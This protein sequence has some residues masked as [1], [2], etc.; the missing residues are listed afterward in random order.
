MKKEETIKVP[1]DVASAAELG[2]I[3]LHRGFKG[4][5]PTGWNRAK[6]LAVDKQ[7][8]VST[9]RVMRA[10]FARHGPDARTG[11]TSYPGYRKWI[12][13][14]K[15]LDRDF[16]KYR[17]AVAWLI[18]GGDPAYIWLKSQKIV[19]MLDKKNNTSKSP[20]VGRLRFNSRR[21]RM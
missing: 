13:N 9:L 15:P 16:S 4:G 3:M 12:E 8:D 1:R 19:R 20:Q 18:W 14:G 6:Q 2:L 7:V 5:T 17:G 10:W 21:A 11:G